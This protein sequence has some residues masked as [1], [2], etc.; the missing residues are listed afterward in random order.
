MNE[1]IAEKLTTIAQNQN[2]ILGKGQ[3]DGWESGYSS[4]WTQLENAIT[5]KGKRTHYGYAFSN[6]DFSGFAFNEKGIKPVDSITNMF[7]TYQG[8]SLPDGIDCSQAKG[9]PDLMFR[10]AKLEEIYDIKLPAPDVYTQTFA[11]MPNIKKIAVV[12]CKEST[13]FDRAFENTTSL[14]DV[15]FEGVIG[16]NGL[17]LRK[18]TVLS[19][20]SLI[21]LFNCLQD[22]S[23]DTSSTTWAVTL[24][25]VN[26][27]KL[28]DADIQIATN[29]GWKLLD[30]NG[31]ARN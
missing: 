9:K 24:G 28:A 6:Q 19:I 16:Q 5:N 27:D 11:G 20:P 2:N 23:Q 13:T 12:R 4:A 14:V 31:V 10:Y 29:K 7:W 18:A 25:T 3:M 22:K 30:D 8:K 15:T 1:K 26:L 21:S 17:D